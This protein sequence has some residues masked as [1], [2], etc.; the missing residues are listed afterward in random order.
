MIYQHETEIRNILYFQELIKI[1]IQKKLS[2]ASF[3]EHP[4][5]SPIGQTQS[6]I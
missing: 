5:Q 2:I 3:V 4:L 6:M 1:T